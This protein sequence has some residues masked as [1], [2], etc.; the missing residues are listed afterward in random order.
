MYR[1]IL[2][3]PKYAASYTLRGEIGASQMKRRI[4]TGRIQYKM[5][6]LNGKNELLKIALELTTS[7]QI[8][9]T[10]VKDKC[11]E[12]IGTTNTELLKM[13]KEKLK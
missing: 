12:L 6:I 10:K 2:G 3:A 7:R 1:Q 4:I 9:W 5:K 11:M 8:V 13:P